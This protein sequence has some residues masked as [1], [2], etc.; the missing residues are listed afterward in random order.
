MRSINVST[1]VFAAIW[2][3]R[4]PGEETEDDIL[5][6]VLDTKT[7]ILKPKR[8]TIVDRSGFHDRRY[9]VHF[10]EGFEIFRTYLGKDYRARATNGTWLL[11]DDGRRYGSLNELSRHR[12]KD[13]ERLVQLVLSR[14]GRPASARVG[15]A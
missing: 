7:P 5:R 12:G 3:A 11:L 8:V 1:E 10:S 15:Y 2:A 13:R 14:T 9:D 4:Q 6:R